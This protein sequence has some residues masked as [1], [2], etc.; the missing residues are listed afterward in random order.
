MTT[1][2]VA[3]H[4]IA[5]ST[6]IGRGASAS[7][8]EAGALPNTKLPQT[9]HRPPPYPSGTPP[10]RHARYGTGGRRACVGGYGRKLGLHL[11][12][13]RPQPHLSCPL[14]YA[15]V[16]A[17]SDRPPGSYLL[18]AVE[19]GPLRRLA[20]G[21]Y[22]AS[23]P[24]HLAHAAPQHRLPPAQMCSRG[25]CRAV[26]GLPSRIGVSPP[27]KVGGYSRPVEPPGAPGALLP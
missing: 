21:R 15:H 25:P 19:L 10:C 9:Q 16:G 14:R 5:S 3:G 20:C 11:W 18:G 24:L 27:L 12:C 17:G 22:I 26:P 1:P 7:L 8:G 2:G 4:C 6:S 23:P 13:F